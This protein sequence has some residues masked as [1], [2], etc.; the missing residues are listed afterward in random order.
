[1]KKFI[2]LL[3]SVVMLFSIG[4]MS[5]TAANA[6]KE[7]LCEEFQELENFCLWYNGISPF[8][9]YALVGWTSDHIPNLDDY[10]YSEKNEEEDY[11]FFGFK[12]PADV[13]EEY[14]NKYFAFDGDL[15][16][17]VR[18]AE[19]KDKEQG[20]NSFITYDE[21][22]DEYL[23][24]YGGYGGFSYV[25]GLVGYIKE[26]NNYSVYIQN[27]PITFDSLEGLLSYEGI[28]VEE[29]GDRLKTTEDGQ[30]YLE[31]PE[32]W[33]KYIKM[34]VAYDGE[35]VKLIAGE[36]IDTM[37]DI[38]EMI[39]PVKKPV[40]TPT[41]ETPEGVKVEGDTAFPENTVVKVE[42]V[43][44]GESFER[45]EKSLSNIAVKDK[46]AVFE[47]TATADNVAVQP[48]G[49]VRVSFDLPNNL[50]ADNLKMFY[51]AE[52]GKTEEIKITVNADKKTIVSE[53][54]HFSIYV[55]C[56]VKPADNTS[57][58]QGTGNPQTGDTTNAV[59]FVILLLASVAVPSVPTYT[60]KKQHNH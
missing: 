30:Y 54:E 49:K 40:N 13:L 56:N 59:L 35:Y 52:D 16:T 31:L 7:N 20:Y 10:E 8:N 19:E 5:A 44:K 3:L 34:T 26:T 38:S 28:T 29:A 17:L 48:N 46:I 2:S 39:T 50:S 1:M 32:A 24:G 58:G 45:A 27:V 25:Y 4:I 14:A 18:E 36:K 23:Y 60:K 11:L 33:K 51:V 43:N 12:V 21:N 22:T 42:N 53:L 37:P 15:R 9:L 41:Y 57:N 55:L 6:E 47:F